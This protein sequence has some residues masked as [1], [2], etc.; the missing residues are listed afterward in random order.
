MSLAHEPVSYGQWSD[1]RNNAPSDPARGLVAVTKSD[2]TVY[3]PPLRALYVGG[4]GN[5]AILAPDDEA[6]VTL[7]DV[8]AGT[9]LPISCAKVMSANT[10]AT[11]LVGLR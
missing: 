10:T 7:T 11:L 2:A 9:I 4:G 6:A 3:D 5:V 8:P 1:Q